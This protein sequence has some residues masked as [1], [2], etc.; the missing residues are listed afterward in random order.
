M[1]NYTGRKEMKYRFDCKVGQLEDDIIIVGDTM[2]E[3]VNRLD[4]KFF[5]I[6]DLI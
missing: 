3:E 5:I 6:E 2:K 4:E 1:E